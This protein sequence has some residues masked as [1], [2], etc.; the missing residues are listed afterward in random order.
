MRP[1]SG[2]RILRSRRRERPTRYEAVYVE[3]TH[4]IDRVLDVAWELNGQAFPTLTTAATWT[5]AN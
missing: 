2:P 3:T 1:M 4:P 5:S